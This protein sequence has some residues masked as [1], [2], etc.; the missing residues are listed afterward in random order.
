[1]KEGKK[2]E[3]EFPQT[4]PQESARRGVN[5]KTITKTTEFREIEGKGVVGGSKACSF[6]LPN[7]LLSCLCWK[8]PPDPL[9]SRIF[10]NLILEATKFKQPP[11]FL[12]KRKEKRK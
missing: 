5:R 9:P 1:M 11:T 6:Y 12:F 8:F 3:T 10:T 4:N 2:G 7:K